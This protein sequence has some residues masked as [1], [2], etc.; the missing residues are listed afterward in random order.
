MTQQGGAMYKV[1]TPITLYAYNNSTLCVYN[2]TIRHVLL[3]ECTVSC[4]HFTSLQYNGTLI[5]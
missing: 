2:V 4:V 3:L 5:Y 1:K